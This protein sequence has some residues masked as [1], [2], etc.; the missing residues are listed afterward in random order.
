MKFIEQLDVYLKIQ[1][2]QL[3]KLICYEQD[4]DYIEMINILKTIY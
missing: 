2:I 3:I 4:W 1:N